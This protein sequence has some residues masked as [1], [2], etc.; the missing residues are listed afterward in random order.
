MPSCGLTP[1]SR[2]RDLHRPG[3]TIPA[4]KPFDFSGNQRLNVNKVFQNRLRQK[5]FRA[6]PEIFAVDKMDTVTSDA[7]KGKQLGALGSPAV[8]PSC[9]QTLQ[10]VR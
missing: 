1:S 4:H 7:R 9:N 10:S 2:N 3:R 8:A 5:R 6:M